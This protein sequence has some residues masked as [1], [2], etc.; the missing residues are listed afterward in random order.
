MATAATNFQIKTSEGKYMKRFLFL[1]IAA[2]SLFTLNTDARITSQ[3]ECSASKQCYCSGI[4]DVRD[5]TPK[6]NPVYVENDPNGHYC[7]CKQWDID[8]YEERCKLRNNK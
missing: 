8:N 1:S 3:E 4:C 6:D 5:V 7:Y 2:V